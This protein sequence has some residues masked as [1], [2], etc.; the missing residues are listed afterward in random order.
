MC[1]ASL[2]SQTVGSLT[3]P[4]SFCGVC[5]FKPAVA[6][7]GSDGVMPFSPTLD[8]VGFMARC[9]TDLALLGGVT[10]EPA[11]A[12]PRFAVLGGIFDERAEPLMRAAMDHV[13]DICRP[14]LREMPAIA[15]D[16]WR[17]LRIVMAAEAA[18]YHGGRLRRH[19]DDYPPKIRELVEEGLRVPDADYQAA[20]SHREAVRAALDET[21]A[22]IVVLLTPATVGPAPDRSTTGDA[23]FNAPWTYTGLPTVSLPIGRTEEGLP[24]AVQLVA[25]AGDEARLFAAAAWLE[26]RVGFELGLPPTPDEHEC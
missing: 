12:A 5:S 15:A 9:V 2:G 11:D 7:A 10:T 26:G 22:G 16:L 3:R 17:Q 25:A 6:D 8:H 19:P 24:L 18:A 1:L 21:L 14:E 23:V 13:R 20:L 4:A